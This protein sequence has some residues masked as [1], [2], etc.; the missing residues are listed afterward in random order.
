MVPSKNVCIVFL[1]GTSMQTGLALEE[2]NVL[3]TILEVGRKEGLTV[4]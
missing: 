1:I 3:A 2:V 4:S